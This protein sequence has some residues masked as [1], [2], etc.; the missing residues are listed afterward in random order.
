[1]HGLPH[2]TDLSFLAGRYLD[3]VCFEQGRL[4]LFFEASLLNKKGTDIYV[5][6][7]VIHHSKNGVIEW[8]CTKTLADSCSLLMLFRI[9][10]LRGAGMPDGTLKLEFSNEE[11]VTIPVGNQKEESYRICD[12]DTIIV[13]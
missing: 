5:Q 4:S 10:I 3:G 8:D 1:M 7:K 11:V 6:S 13:V 9:T 2:D 12:G